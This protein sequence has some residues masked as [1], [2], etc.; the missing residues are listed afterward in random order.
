MDTIPLELQKRDILGKQNSALRR[1]GMTPAH[2]FGHGVKSVALQGPTSEIEKVVAT[3]GTSRLIGLKIGSE[4]RARHVLIREIQRKPG[5]GMLLHVDFYQVRS[6][7][8]MVAE[9]PVHVVGE[10]PVLESKANSLVVDMPTLSVECLP[11]KIPSTISIDVSSLVDTDDVI[12]VHDVNP[13]EGI[14]VL[15]SPDL[16]VVKIEVERRRVE[17]VAEAVEEGVE[18]VPAKQPETPEEPGQ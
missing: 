3:A 4:K 2:V 7:E 18:V 12:R 14:T 17:E 8:K 6:K 16:V 15:N 10:A 1:T 5:T 11:S 13:G 9:V